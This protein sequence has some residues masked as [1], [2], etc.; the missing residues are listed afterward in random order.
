MNTR[1]LIVD[2]DK[3]ILDVISRLLRAACIIAKAD[4]DKEALRI[5]GGSGDF[6]VVVAS[7]S[8]PEMDG[9]TLL[10]QVADL[11]PETKRILYTSASDIRVAIDAVNK[12]QVFGFI[13]KPF[14]REAFISIVMQA[15]EEYNVQVVEKELLEKTLQSSIEVLI[16]ILGMVDTVSFSR[17]NRIYRYVRDMTKYLQIANSWPLKIAALLSQI[18]CVSLSTELVEKSTTGFTQM[19]K[20]EQKEFMAHATLGANMIAN[21]PRMELVAE[22]IQHQFYDLGFSRMEYDAGLASD[23]QVGSHLLNVAYYYDVQFMNGRTQ[24]EIIH[25]MGQKSEQFFGPFVKALH[26]VTM[27]SEEGGPIRVGLDNLHPGMLL[28]DDVYSENGLLLAAKSQEVTTVMIQRLRTYADSHGL[29][30]PL[31]AHKP[32]IV[33]DDESKEDVESEHQELETNTE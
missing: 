25:E 10:K 20:E 14:E 24:Q 7:H 17:A 15:I 16:D 18:G 23:Q 5:L 2:D 13:E 4:N 11:Y 33:P 26:K 27:V 8:M 29:K 28:A 12:G 19:D 6:A 3:R 22:I 31:L 30:L 21:I 9:I 1:A 32:R